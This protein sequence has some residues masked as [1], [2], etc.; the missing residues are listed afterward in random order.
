V[1]T[2][3]NG[4]MAALRIT[5]GGRLDNDFSTRYLRDRRSAARE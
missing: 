5:A 3:H 4:N 2:L 1:A